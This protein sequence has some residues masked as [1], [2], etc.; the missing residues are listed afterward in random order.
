M[1]L[2]LNLEVCKIIFL[3]SL[4]YIEDLDVADQSAQGEDVAILF[5]SNI[6][7]KQSL[8]VNQ[9]NTYLLDSIKF[10]KEKKLN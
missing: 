9:Q 10:K 2:N 3:Y 1:K 5:R 8:S 6:V 4:R 7:I